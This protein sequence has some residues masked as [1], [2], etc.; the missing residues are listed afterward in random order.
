MIVFRAAPRRS[1]A[2][3]VL[4]LTPEH[5]QEFVLYSTVKVGWNCKFTSIFNLIVLQIYVVRGPF[6][7]V[8]T[9]NIKR[10]ASWYFVFSS[11]ARETESLRQIF[12]CWLS[13]QH[14]RFPLS[15]SSPLSNKKATTTHFHF[16]FH[17]SSL[18]S[19]K[20]KM[21]AKKFPTT[22]FISS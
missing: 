4:I 20:M 17:L 10:K 15:L 7:A 9:H 22:D 18:S 5:F 16:Y 13:H 8:P 12:I 2:E 14:D 3:V 1:W 21:A 19:T 11:V 6:Y